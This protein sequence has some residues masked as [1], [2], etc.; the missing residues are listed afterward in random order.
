MADKTRMQLKN[1]T[2]HAISFYFDQDVIDGRLLIDAEPYLTIASEPAQARVSSR[3]EPGDARRIDTVHGPRWVPCVA[4]IWTVA[5]LPAQE[6]DVGYL[7]STLFADHLSFERATA[8]DV[9]V[10][11]SGPEFGVRNAQ[12]QIVGTTR[13]RC[14]RS[15]RLGPDA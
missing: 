10:P 2:P 12:G 7:V 8:G 14:I 1:L 13:L 11:D 4:H 6:P 15:E 5:E 3:A 9:F